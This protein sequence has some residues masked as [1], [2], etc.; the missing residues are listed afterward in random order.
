MCFYNVQ[1]RIMLYILSWCLV[2]WEWNLLCIFF[3]KV[4]HCYGFE[5]EHAEMNS[6]SP[7]SFPCM[8]S[9]IPCTQE[10]SVSDVMGVSTSY[11]YVICMKR[12]S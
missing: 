2:T 12:T 5:R 11:W 3:L 10:I 1:R 6:H 8:L 9:C 7:T 4:I